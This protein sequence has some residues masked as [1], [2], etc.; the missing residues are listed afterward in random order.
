MTDRIGFAPHPYLGS[1]HVCA[2]RLG[3]KI[4]PKPE[5]EKKSYLEECIK[6]PC[7]YSTNEITEGYLHSLIQMAEIAEGSL[8]DNIG[9]LYAVTRKPGECDADFRKRIMGRWWV[10]L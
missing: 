3:E 9:I 1:G 5:V 2:V 8:L 4:E 7:G 6:V 10:K